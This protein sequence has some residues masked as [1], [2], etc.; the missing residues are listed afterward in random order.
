MTSEGYIPR[1][2]VSDIQTQRLFPTQIAVINS[3]IQPTFNFLDYFT[4]F[5][6][7][8]FADV[9]LFFQFSEN[10]GMLPEMSKR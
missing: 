1:P 8:L 6:L 5:I 7:E 10:T 4:E 9:F 2:A 3:T